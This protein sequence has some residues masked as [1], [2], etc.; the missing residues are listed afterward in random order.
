MELV[1]LGC[2]AGMPADGR[3]SS[4]YLVV[5]S[6]CRILL[7]CGPG[8]AAALSAHGGAGSLDAVVVTHLHP[9]H[10]YDLLPIGISRRN[11]AAPLP[12]YVPAA[13]GRCCMT[14]ASCSPRARTSRSITG[15]PSGSTSPGS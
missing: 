3:A 9:D 4:G 11:A 6:R 13:G 7:D 2:Q 14:W 1:V 12:L 5:T 15:S 8:V 10:C